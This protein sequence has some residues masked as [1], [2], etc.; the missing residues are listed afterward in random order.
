MRQFSFKSIYSCVSPLYLVRVPHALEDGAGKSNIVLTI[1][2][3][4][5]AARRWWRGRERGM[6]GRAGTAPPPCPC[7]PP[8]PDPQFN[9]LGDLCDPECVT[10]VSL[11]ISLSGAIHFN[12][13]GLQREQTSLFFI[14]PVNSIQTLTVSLHPARMIP[15]PGGGCPRGAPVPPRASRCAPIPGPIAPRPPLESTVPCP[16]EV[17]PLFFH[18]ILRFECAVA[19]EKNDRL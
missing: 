15:P 5:S 3:S 11:H 10:T 7:P 6:Y 1:N 13:L 12:L 4:G 19:R 18:L 14:I 2:F 8:A 16:V 9:G 17:S